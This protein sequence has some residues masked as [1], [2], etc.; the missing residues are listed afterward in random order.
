MGRPRAD[1]HYVRRTAALSLLLAVSLLVLPGCG[2]LLGPSVDYRAEESS[3][4]D[5]ETAA[6]NVRAAIPAIEAYYADNA[7]YEG[8]TADVL[9]RTYDQGI[10][11]VRITRADIQTYCISSTVGSATVSKHGPTGDL[12]PGGC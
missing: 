7:T 11:D 8:V 12:Q 1:G 10:G 5:E 3:S 4:S 2:W 6:A 9:R